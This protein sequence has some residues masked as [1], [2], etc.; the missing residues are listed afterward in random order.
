MVPDRTHFAGLIVTMNKNLDREMQDKYEVVVEAED[1]QGRRGESGT[2]TVFITLQDVNDNFPIFT[3][4]EPLSLG[5]GGVGG[6]QGGAWRPFTSPSTPEWAYIRDAFPV[7]PVSAHAPKAAH[8]AC[9]DALLGHQQVTLPVVC[10]VPR[11]PLPDRTSFTRSHDLRKTHEPGSRGSAERQS[12][13]WALTHPQTDSPHRKMSNKSSSHALGGLG[14]K[15][16]QMAHHLH[17]QG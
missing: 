15:V 5:P 3:Q 12:P 14:R 9:Q 8:P 13:G 1:A 17:L 2:A 11:V 6:P 7:P 10:H 4:S 16:R